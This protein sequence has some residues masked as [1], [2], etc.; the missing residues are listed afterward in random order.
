MVL[1]NILYFIFTIRVRFLNTLQFEF[2]FYLFGEF[3]KRFRIVKTE[4]RFDLKE[5][6]ARTCDPTFTRD[7]FHAYI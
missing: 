3:R 6:S 4:F 2:S 5:F 7:E 1:D